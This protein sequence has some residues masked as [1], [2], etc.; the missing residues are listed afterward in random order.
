M[1]L[2]TVKNLQWR[3]FFIDAAVI[4]GASMDD[5]QYVSSLL[6]VSDTFSKMVVVIL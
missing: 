1:T 5:W 2:K 6:P 3:V 4:S